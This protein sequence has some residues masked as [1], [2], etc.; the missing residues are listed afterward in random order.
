MA[1]GESRG[2]QGGVEG[3]VEVSFLSPPEPDPSSTH[4]HIADE[5]TSGDLTTLLRTNQT[6]T[7]TPCFLLLAS[8]SC[9]LLSLSYRSQ[10]FLAWTC[11]CGETVSGHI[12]S[13]I[14]SARERDRRAK[15]EWLHLGHGGAALLA[16]F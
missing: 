9:L 4:D 1:K 6:P 2:V 8:C 10:S 13:E 15:E 5:A 3:E 16:A 7:L 12:C 14:I 11:V